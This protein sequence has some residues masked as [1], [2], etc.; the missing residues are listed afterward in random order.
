MVALNFKAQ[1][2][3]DVELERKC[4][5]IRAPRKDGRNPKRG[6]KLQ[7]YTG[8]RQAGCRKLRDATVT[9]VRPVE[10]D[11]LGITLDGRKL[12]AGDAPAYQGGPDPEAWD[13]DFARADGFDAFQDMLEFFEKTHGLPFHGFLIEWR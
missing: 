4:R 8:M 12:Y 7:L 3:D 10:I 9:R 2:A 1:F 5:S 6:D 11:H 13:G